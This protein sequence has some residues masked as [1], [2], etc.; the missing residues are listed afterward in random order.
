MV[1]GCLI[2]EITSSL[3][4]EKS[5]PSLRKL[6]V[7]WAQDMGMSMVSWMILQ[8]ARWSPKMPGGCC[9]QSQLDCAPQ[10]TSAGDGR[11]EQGVP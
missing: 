8:K 6:K 1:R 4:E 10:E 5:E 9:E 3:Y 11:R 7:F 2:P